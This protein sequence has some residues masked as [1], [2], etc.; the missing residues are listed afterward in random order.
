M[1]KGGAVSSSRTSPYAL[2]L[3]FTHYSAI[4]NVIWPY[5]LH[6]RKRTMHPRDG[7]GK[8]V[9]FS[10]MRLFLK[11]LDV[12]MLLSPPFSISKTSVGGVS[13]CMSNMQLIYFIL[14][15]YIFAQYSN[16]FEMA[17]PDMRFN[18]VF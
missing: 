18:V 13:C 7:F 2:Y 11:Y 5:H 14:S 12:T 4:S 8:M 10:L 17:V 16:E 6:I 1:Q 15:N 3:T 9:T